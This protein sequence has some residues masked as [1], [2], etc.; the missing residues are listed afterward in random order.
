MSRG[1]VIATC[2]DSDGCGWTATVAQI[3]GA[4]YTDPS[5]LDADPPDACPDCGADVTTE[6][7][8][9]P[10]EEPDYPEEY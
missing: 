2:T 1:Y 5:Y 8:S 9:Q 7:A 3:I 6:T 4:T 10:I